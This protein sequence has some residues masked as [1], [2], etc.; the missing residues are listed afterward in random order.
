ML[1]RFNDFFKHTL[2]TPF[3]SSYYIEFIGERKTSAGSLF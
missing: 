1:D 2:I 3:L